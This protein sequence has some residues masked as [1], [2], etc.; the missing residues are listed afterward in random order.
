MCAGF[1]VSVSSF[2][3]EKCP[4]HPYWVIPCLRVW[5]L[6]KLPS[7]FLE[8]FYCFLF[9]RAVSK[10]SSCST[11]S[12]A[13]VTVTRLFIFIIVTA[14]ILVH[15]SLMVNGVKHICIQLIGRGP[16]SLEG[17][18]LY[19]EATDFLVNLIPKH[20]HRDI[21]EIHRTK[22]LGTMAQPS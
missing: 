5:V 11:Y 13:F 15:S 3:R 18:L 9:P 10:R 22:S 20:P 12:P 7:W 2:L 8:P 4:E 1:G 17:D 16:P 14:M 21:Q 6:E 19:S